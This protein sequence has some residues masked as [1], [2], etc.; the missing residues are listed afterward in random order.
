[1]AYKKFR[2]KRPQ[3]VKIDYKPPFD[4][5]LLKEPVSSLRLREDTQKLLDG[6]S[7]KTLY[8][9]V[10]REDKDYY[11]IHTFNK[12]NLM[13]VKNALRAK[14][15]YLRPTEEKT[16]ESVKEKKP[17]KEE[18][19]PN[20]EERQE[21]KQSRSD[22]SEGFVSATKVERP[23]RPKPVV[24]KEEPDI[25]VKV[26][27]GGKWGFKDRTGKQVVEPVY[28]EVFSFKGDLC[29]VEKDE[30]FGYINR[31]GEIIIPIEYDCATS[32]SEGYA[33]VFRKDKCG[34]IDVNNGVVIDF[35]F[36]AGT[37]IIDGECRVKKD[38]KW[39]ELHLIKDEDGVI[40]PGEIRWIV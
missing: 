4:E 13:D 6:A 9:L 23:E 37:P 18:K 30:K 16:E 39:G 36:D 8:D 26:N 7:L 27:R 1:M 12:K 5:N 15:L 10:V 11:R 2:H 29:C 14:K 19:K 32:F 20:K 38:G 40:T 28:D 17:I 34:Y 25:Y 35:V 24:V 22:L 31:Q 3:Q 33:C 21:G